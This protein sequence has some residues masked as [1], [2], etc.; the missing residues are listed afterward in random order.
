[1]LRLVWEATV[2]CGFSSP[3]LATTRTSV[4]AFE[5]ETSVQPH[6]AW[7]TSR[8]TNLPSRFHESPSSGVPFDIRIENVFERGGEGGAFIQVGKR[9]PG[10]LGLMAPLVN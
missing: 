3:M 7:K 1:M 5:T 6:R 2:G 8:A 9:R 10:C 4:L